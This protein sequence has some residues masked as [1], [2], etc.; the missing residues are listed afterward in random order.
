MSSRRSC[1]ESDK[2]VSMMW[3]SEKGRKA[4][5]FYFFFFEHLN[6]DSNLAS[7]VFSESVLTDITAT[8]YQS[9]RYRN[10]KKSDILIG[11]TPTLSEGTRESN[12]IRVIF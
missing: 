8:S 11:L 3:S 5:S 7:S 4:L 9:N 1:R 6:M 10:S 2:S 12:L